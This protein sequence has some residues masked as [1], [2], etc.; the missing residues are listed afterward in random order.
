[1]NESDEVTKSRT[2]TSDLPRK[3]VEGDRV[4][5]LD[6]GIETTATIVKIRRIDR[7]PNGDISYFCKVEFADGKE[8]FATVP[9]SALIK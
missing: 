5:L 9:S 6:D 7:Y 3:L 1:M 2:Y 4:R 8:A